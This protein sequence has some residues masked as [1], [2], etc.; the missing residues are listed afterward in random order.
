MKPSLTDQEINYSE[1][2]P[3]EMNKLKSSYQLGEFITVF[4]KTKI[5]IKNHPNSFNV[6]NFYAMACGSLNMF[7]KAQ[8]GFEKAAKLNPNSSD[9]YNNLGVILQAQNKLGEAL[10]NFKRGAK[11]NPKN[12]QIQNNIGILHQLEHL[13]FLYRL[14]QCQSYT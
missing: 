8:K 10:K 3:E 5:L 14:N 2:S 4:D 12:F 9:T 6:W 1:P 11:L 7:Q 13:R